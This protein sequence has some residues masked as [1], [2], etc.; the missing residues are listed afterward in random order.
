M[1]I[2]KSVLPTTEP[3]LNS[4]LA[5]KRAA[6]GIQI[7][8]DRTS[9]QRDTAER[10]IL[11]D[12]ELATLRSSLDEFTIDFDEEFRSLW[13]I[14]N[15]RNRPC[16]TTKVLD[17]II[18]I[19]TYL[20]QCRTHPSGPGAAPRC[21]I[22]ASGTPGVFNLGGDLE[23]F[24]NLIRSGNE[25]ELR[26]Y[27]YLCVDTV[28]NNLTNVGLPILNLTL[29]QGDALGGGFEA[30]LSSDIIIAERQSKFGLPEILFNLFPGMGAY[31]LLC[32]RL[33]GGKAKEMILSGKLYSAEELYDLGV[34]DALAEP[35]EGRAAA[36]R[37]IEQN[38]RRYRTLLALGDV[39][40]RCQPIFI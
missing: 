2:S 26:K 37:Y 5:R 15:H 20:G 34:I 1:A 14:Y 38:Q 27:A 3:E 4:T 28:Y 12:F 22:W 25:D 18:A 9:Y 31:S 8:P 30:A 19:Q 36:R 17:E 6:S 13:C 11:V 29:V 21:L 33:D 23:L 35:G 16:Y 32:R 40:R 39:R 24:I 10:S 7:M